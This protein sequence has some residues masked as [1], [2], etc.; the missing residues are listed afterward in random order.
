MCQ[1]DCVLPGDQR[2]PQA[3]VC[4]LKP[5][6][7]GDRTFNTSEETRIGTVVGLEAPDFVFCKSR[8]RAGMNKSQSALSK[9]DIQYQLGTLA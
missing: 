6:E 1:C 2:P 5:R 3:S 4:E 9:W 8:S 7:T